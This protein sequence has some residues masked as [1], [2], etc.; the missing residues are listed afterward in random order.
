MR[1]NYLVV[2][3]YPIKGVVDGTKPRRG[4]NCGDW[5]RRNPARG[6]G[7]C[8]PSPPGAK[9]DRM[10]VKVSLVPEESARSSRNLAGLGF[11]KKG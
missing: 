10:M 1:V 2:C 4:K 11:K 6:R 8:P 7:D 5:G 9:G 3:H